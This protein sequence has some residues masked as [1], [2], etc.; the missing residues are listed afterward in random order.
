M[1]SIP[2]IPAGTAGNDIIVGFVSD[3]WIDG[4]LGND[5]LDG[6]ASND[7]LLGGDGADLLIGGQGADLLCGGAGDDQFFGGAG[8]DTLIGGDGNDRLQ[9]GGG[10]DLLQGDAGN[11]VLQAH[12]GPSDGREI[13]RLYG[14]AGADT[15]VITNGWAKGGGN[16]YAQILD[17]CPGEGDRLQFTRGTHYSTKVSGASTWIY[18]GADVVALINGVNLGTGSITASTSWATFI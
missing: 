16:D 8:N 4:G 1:T 6:G 15:F 14:G 9:S 17:F 7:T 5:T 18:S 10:N 3:D 11:D 13:D 12:H 2:R